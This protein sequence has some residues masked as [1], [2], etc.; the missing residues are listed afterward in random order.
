MK[1]ENIVEYIVADTNIESITPSF[2]CENT[3]DEVT[4]CG[5]WLTGCVTENTKF[6][7]IQEKI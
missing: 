6:G 1:V 4:D 7:S 5:I 2:Y 3:W